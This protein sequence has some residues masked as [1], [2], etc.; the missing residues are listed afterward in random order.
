MLLSQTIRPGAQPAARG[1]A[2]VLPLCI[3]ESLRDHDRPEEVLEDENL[4]ISLPRRLG[5]NDVIDNQ[6][7]RYE[8]ARRKRRPVPVNELTDLLRLVIRR[9]DDEA[10]LQEA[11]E[12][13]V[14][15]FVAGGERRR[16]RLARI[17]PGRLR[18]RMLRR[19]L[20]RLARRMAA[21]GTVE[22]LRDPVGVRIAP[23]IAAA[24]DP[25]GVACLL[26]TSAFRTL[27]REYGDTDARIVHS[28]CE[29]R[30]QP[31]CE[32]TLQG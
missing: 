3:L 29:T 2:A 14:G 5:L 8:E 10:I 12:S 32:W 7:R 20:Q 13:I 23:C 22:V 4:A 27:A 28:A 26:Y 19:A 9:P 1:V 25:G 31:A 24:V 15:R 6:I 16:A 17:M 18:R 21:G 11:G 30:G